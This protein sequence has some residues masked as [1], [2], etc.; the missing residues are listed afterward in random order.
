MTTHTESVQLV[1]VPGFWLG[2]WAWDDVVGP[3]RAA[4]HE[5][6]PITLPGLEGADVDR[7]AIT[8][9]DHVRAVREVVESLPPGVVLVGHSGGG[10]VVH[11]VV[12]QVPDRVRRAIYVDSGPL[13]DGA[14]LALDLPATGSEIPL[15]AWE[16][17][18]AAGSSLEGLDA[19]ALEAFRARAVPHPAGVAREAMRLT[20]RRRLGVPVTV[21]CTSLPSAV[22]RTMTGPDSPLRT[23]LGAMDVTYVDLPTGHWPMFSRPADLA[24]AIASA[25][26]ASS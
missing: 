10:A 5:P 9:E 26:T 7:S 1:L 12:D 8:R 15:P 13:A 6:H 18:E 19:A 24:A 23:E 2:G 25:A 20:D 21:I 4:G 11:A 3:L 22:L 17:L 16:E 14:A